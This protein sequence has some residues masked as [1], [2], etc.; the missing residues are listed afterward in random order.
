M[1]WDYLDF[2][3]SGEWQAIQERYEDFDKKGTICNPLRQNLF[4]ALDD[5]PLASTRVAFFGQDPY[6]D[7]QYATGLAF[8]IP[9]DAKTFPPTLLNIFKEMCDNDLHYPFPSSGCLEPWVAQGVLLWNVIPSCTAYAS[10]SHDWPEWEFLNKEIIEK[11]NDNGVVCVFFGGVAREYAKLVKDSNNVI[12]VS[13]PSPRGS[14][15]AKHPFEGSRI[16]SRV[17][18]K[19]RN[20]GFSAIDWRL[21]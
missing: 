6:P 1:T 10:M 16:F 17:N 21:P 8:S 15:N 9:K 3:D 5:C 12:E 7:P 18:E 11:L 13:H 2:W 20:V 14:L 4:R 19:L